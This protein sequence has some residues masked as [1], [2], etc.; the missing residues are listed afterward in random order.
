MLLFL[1][2]EK[3]RSK[4]GRVKKIRRHFY[5][6]KKKTQPIRKTPAPKPGK[7]PRKIDPRS[8][9]ADEPENAQN[10][11]KIKAKRR[12]DKE[13]GNGELLKL[14]ND[15]RNKLYAKLSENDR[16]VFIQQAAKLDQKNSAKPGAAEIDRFVVVIE[17]LRC[18]LNNPAIATKHNS[19]TMFLTPSVP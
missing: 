2:N 5:N 14:H 15:I 8:L 6:A 12:I 16:Q 4:I 17:H 7:K 18:K 1:I 11:A 9:F 19:P 10:I 13:V 3:N